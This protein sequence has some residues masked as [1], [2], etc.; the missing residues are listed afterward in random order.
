M[1]PAAIFKG[2]DLDTLICR[3]ETMKPVGCTGDS[4][5]MDSSHNV[6]RPWFCNDAVAKNPKLMW[7][8]DTLGIDL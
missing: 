7:F 4:S 2:D 8:W 3:C 5:P 6:V 1:R